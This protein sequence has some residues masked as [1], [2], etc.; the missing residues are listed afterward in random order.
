MYPNMSKLRRRK[1]REKIVRTTFVCSS[2]QTEDI[3]MHEISESLYWKLGI[4]KISTDHEIKIISNF[5]W[6]LPPSILLVH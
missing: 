2:E 1:K 3:P 6:Y 5:S 4:L